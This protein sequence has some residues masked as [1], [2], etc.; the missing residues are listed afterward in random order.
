M[1]GLIPFVM[2]AFLTSHCFADDPHGAADHEKPPRALAPTDPAVREDV[3]EVSEQDAIALD[4][5][6]QEMQE[7][8]QKQ[9]GVVVYQ[10]SSLID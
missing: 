5:L 10:G 9:S 8:L 1:R 3:F 6:A 7:F 4:K 2:L